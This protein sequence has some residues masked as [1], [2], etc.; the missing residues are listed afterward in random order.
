MALYNSRKDKYYYKEQIEEF[1][2]EVAK[3]DISVCRDYC[4]KYQYNNKPKGK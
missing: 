1:Y 4:M 3:V 2:K